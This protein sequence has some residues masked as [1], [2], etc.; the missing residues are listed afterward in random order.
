VPTQP[1]P[2][3]KDLRDADVP[4]MAD[5][6]RTVLVHNFRPDELI[7]EEE[8]NRGVREGETRVL[9]TYAPDG[10]I[11]GGAVGDWF[12]SSR[13]QLLSY[14]AVRP[15]LRGQGLGSTLLTEAV[16]AWTAEFEP[17]LIVGEVEDPRYHHDTEFG[18]A[19][20][21]VRLYERLGARALP[22][23]YAQPALKPNG[24]RVPHLMLMVFA[25]E[26]S[27]YLSDGHVDGNIIERFL[28][29]YF[30]ACEGPA[31]P[32]D[33]ELTALLAACRVSGGLP[34]LLAHEL[35]TFEPT[36]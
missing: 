3:V 15:G 22:L 8:L 31:L 28:R 12:G 30:E 10:T 21:R 23:P 7:S 32:G 33:D 25:G 34:S 17:L 1:A 35:P 2:A 26:A 5:F 24:R 11:L 20:A 27:A 13:V 29:E 4:T 6:Y 14:I 16:R 36:D 18:D 19:S 9:A